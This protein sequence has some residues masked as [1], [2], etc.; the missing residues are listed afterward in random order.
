[1]DRVAAELREGPGTTDALQ[2]ETRATAL[3]K[4]QSSLAALNI[5]GLLT[6]DSAY[7]LAMAATAITIFVFGLLL[8]RRREYVTLRAQGMRIGKIRS[9][10]VTESVGV[11]VVGAVAGTFVG[12]VMAYFL[13]KVLQ[14]LFVLR[15]ELVLPRADIAGLAALVLA[16]SVAAS[17]AAT[18]LIRRLPP[19]ELL[20]DE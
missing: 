17:L 7:A 20:R 11:V 19:G 4:D 10:L 15:P 2:F 13:V 8:Q 5:R 12:G 9:L 18:T 3:D 1:L 16:V 14:P 6:L